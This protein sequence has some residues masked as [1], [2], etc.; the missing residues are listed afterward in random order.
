MTLTFLMSLGQFC[1]LVFNLGLSDVS[2]AG[3]AFL[4]EISQKWCVFLRSPY[5][6]ALHTP[7]RV[8]FNMHEGVGETL[9]RGYSPKNRVGR[10]FQVMFTFFFDLSIW[11]TQTQQAFSPAT[12]HLQTLP[13]HPL[14]TRPWPLMLQGKA[15]H[16][17]K[18]KKLHNAIFGFC[19]SNILGPSTEGI[20][21][22]PF[23]INAFFLLSS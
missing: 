3:S 11:C 20:T 17:Q 18:V 4:A 21:L 22:G 12:Y 7:L 8:A 16:S 10:G 1:R 14:R 2:S 19:I 9:E 15:G 13:S 5:Q 23:L 6:E